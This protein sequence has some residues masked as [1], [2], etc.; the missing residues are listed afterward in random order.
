MSKSAIFQIVGTQGPEGIKTTDNSTNS[1]PL[2]PQAD[3]PKDS[4]LNDF[5]E[6]ARTLSEAQ[7]SILVGSIIP[8]IAGCLARRVY[9]KFGAKKY[10]NVYNMVVARPGERKSSTVQIAQEIASRLLA[11]NSFVWGVGSEQALFKTYQANPDKIWI[12]SEGNPMLAN[13]AHDA[14]GKQVAKRMLDLYD[15]QKWNQNYIRQEEENGKASETI[16]ETSTSFLIATTFNSARFN[17]L[18]TRD[19]MRRRTSYYVSEGLARIIHWPAENPDEK[20]ALITG[21]QPLVA[22]SGEMELSADAMELWKAIQDDNRARIKN[23]HGFDQA[24]EALGTTLSESPSKILKRAMLFEICR[25]LTDSRRDWTTIQADTLQISAN[26]EAFCIHSSTVLDTIGM[27][28]EVR[29]EADILLAKIRTDFTNKIT[30]GWISL[31]RSDITSKFASHSNRPSALTPD[32]IYLHIIPDL[33][34][35]GLAKQ[36]SKSGKREVFAFAME[37]RSGGR[38]EIV[39]NGEMS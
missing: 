5:V 12:I 8:V 22:L 1:T 16:T 39:E 13:W 25:W 15:C 21:L 29:N 26:H 23:V 2:P 38:G 9:L 20:N 4:I 27:R 31:T 18:E 19:G 11:E 37:D 7:D 30:D 35:R 17:G 24:A 14:A 36:E 32:R 3:Y 34:K 10:P 28:A 6:Y 33:S